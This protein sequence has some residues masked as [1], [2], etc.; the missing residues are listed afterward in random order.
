MSTYP[1]VLAGQ[2]ITADLLNSMLPQVAY[3]TT[4]EAVTSST[5]M[6]NDDEL[7]VP[8]VAS[9]V[10]LA[11]LFLLYDAAAAG[12]IKIGWTAPSGASLAWTVVG[13]T[14]A[15]TTNTSVSTL[16]MQTRTTSETASLG[17]SSST[18]IGATAYGRLTV[19][20][21][22]G[23]LQFQWAQDTSNGTATNV[24]AGSVLKL[25]RLA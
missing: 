8:V 22:A 24:R 10:Y 18:G 6:Q 20:T 15:E 2:D 9:S 7:F 17:G 5:T 11:E 1:N 25:T 23:N 3:K 16:N 14:T 12:D 19:S 13:A 21:T 4:G